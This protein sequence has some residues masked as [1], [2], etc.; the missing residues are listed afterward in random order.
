MEARDAAANGETTLAAAHGA[1]YLATGV[2]PLVSRRTFE[3]VTGKKQDFWLVE[4]VGALVGVIGATLLAGSVRRRITP[5]LAMLA[6]GSA[7]ALAAI[8]VVHV[9]RRRISPVYLLDAVGE[10]VLLAGW[11]AVRAVRRG[12]SPTLSPSVRRPSDAAPTA[13]S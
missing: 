9:A 1:Y 7:V 6:A 10:A 4:T 8:D 11:T 5:E 2:W 3:A 12:V 13:A